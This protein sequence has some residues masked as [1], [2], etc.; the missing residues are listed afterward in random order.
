VLDNCDNYECD[1]SMVSMMFM[2]Q[3][4]NTH[5]LFCKGKLAGMLQLGRII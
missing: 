2:G 3:R 5:R 1:L 4:R